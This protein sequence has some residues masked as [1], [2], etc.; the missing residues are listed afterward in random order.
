M[1]PRVRTKC[2]HCKKKIL[3][4]EPDLLLEDPTT[5]KLRYFHTRC[6]TAIADLILGEPA[7]YQLMIRHV[8]AERN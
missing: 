4:S 8:E 5:S 7:P 2:A 6:D 1:S 3:P